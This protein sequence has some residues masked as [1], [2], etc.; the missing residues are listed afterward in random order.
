MAKTAAQNH[1]GA[2]IAA[3]SRSRKAN[4][5][6]LLNARREL[7]AANLEKYVSEVVAKAPPLTP[8]QRTRIA[9]L[10]RAGGDAA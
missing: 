6:D 3:L 1:Q 7:A 5:P 2:K 8:E 10:L 9:A 4:D